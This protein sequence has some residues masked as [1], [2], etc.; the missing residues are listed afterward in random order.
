MVA[1]LGGFCLG[2]TAFAE[3]YSFKIPEKD[4]TKEEKLSWS[5]NFYAQY[6]LFHPQESSPIYGVQFADDEIASDNLSQFYSNLY[7]NGNYQTKDI[8]FHL[9][10]HL[11][12]ENNENGTS[13]DVLEIYGNYNLTLNSFIQVGRIQYNWGKGYAFNP[14]G[15]INPL[16]DP[17]DPDAA[18]EGLQS[19]QIELFKS[20][21]SD[22]L[23]T[24]ALTFVVIP[25]EE[26][27][28]DRFAETDQTDMAAKLS[29]SLGTADV[30]LLGYYGDN[31]LSRWGAAFSHNLLTDLEVHGEIAYF[32]DALKSTIVEDQL[33]QAEEEGYASLLGVRWLNPLNMTIIAEYYRN[34]AGLT[35]DEFQSYL[36]FLQQSLDSGNESQ[37]NQAL[38][39]SQQNFKGNTLMQEY[40]YLS[41][42]KPEPF[43]W[44]YFTPS[45][46]VIYNIQDQS[47]LL[48]LTLSYKPV[49]NIELLFKP[50]FM[51]GDD[52]TEYGSQPFKQKVEMSL[53]WSF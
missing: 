35:K 18:K 28:N 37:I 4:E 52:D 5:G 16:K 38:G 10:T 7:L 23:T 3:D 20:F 31:D 30:D 45:V 49:T 17:S 13:F 22:I 24:T 50:T 11:K 32:S 36:D 41:V 2:L 42:Q 44:L 39:Y 48:F 21:S 1:M 47:R 53:I 15:F 25:P 33:F 14:V 34:D 19:A 8:G 12:D 29:L 43:D 27:V 9:K 26:Q 46:S 40:L 51:I 6:S